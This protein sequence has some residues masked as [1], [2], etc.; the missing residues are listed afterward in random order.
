LFRDWSSASNSSPVEGLEVALKR[1]ANPNIKVSIYIFGDEYSGKSY[2]SVIR[3]LQNL[4]KNRI[5]G[6]FLA[7]VHGIGFLSI[8]STGRFAIL[9][10]EV[11]R[12]NGGTF[13]GLP[14]K[15]FKH[16]KIGFAQLPV[17]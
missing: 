16:N 15:K 10:R 13:I 12:L 8:Y 17:D 1:Y 2:G 4:N 11:A 6:S 3:S 14:N 5:N 7:R 9:M